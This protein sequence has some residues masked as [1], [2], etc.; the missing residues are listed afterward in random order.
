MWSADEV[1]KVF[2]MYVHIMISMV[3]VISTLF[4]FEISTG[5]EAQWII[6]DLTRGNSYHVAVIVIP[7]NVEMDFNILF[8]LPSFPGLSLVDQ[9]GFRQWKR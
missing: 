9:A 4:T 5:K 2:L 8:R 1:R 7:V 3:N 6:L